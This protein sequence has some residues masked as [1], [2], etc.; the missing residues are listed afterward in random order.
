MSTAPATNQNKKVMFE[1][2]QLTG[3]FAVVNVEVPV[4]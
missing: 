1:H 3:T 4:A 2:Y